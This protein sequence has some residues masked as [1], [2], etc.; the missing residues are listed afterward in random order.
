MSALLIAF[1]APD[2]FQITLAV[3]IFVGMV[4]GGVGWIPGAFIGALFILFVPNIA[5]HIAFGMAAFFGATSAKRR[6]ES[7]TP[8]IFGRR[9]KDR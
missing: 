1:V 3:A 9:R 7:V 5:E 6:G 4:V 2:S 8:R